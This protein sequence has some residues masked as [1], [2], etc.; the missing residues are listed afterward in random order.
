LEFVSGFLAILVILAF[1]ILIVY[2]LFRVLGDFA[3]TVIVNLTGRN[4]FYHTAFKIRKIQLQHEMILMQHFR[5]YRNLNP[6]KQRIFGSRLEKFMAGKNFINKGDELLTEKKKVLISATAIKLTFGIRKYMLPA[7]PTI[8]V[9]PQQYYSR[10]TGTYNKGE[11]NALGAVVFSWEDYI[12][13]YKIEDD[14][15]NVGLHEFAHA[16]ALQCYLD[17]GNCDKAFS[18]H[19]SRWDEA[20]NHP[21]NSRIIENSG[22]FREY[23]NQNNMELFA[24]AV[25][26]YFENPREFKEK[27]PPLYVIMMRMLNLE[28]V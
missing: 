9:Y 16:L 26:H 6:H 15:L 8:I 11:T 18:Y 4:P 23:A 24:V 5:F 13:G 28:L 10:F 21:S 1:L 14:N 22:L 2:F 19:L 17:S 20:V 3:E 25:E 12:E 7:F 27:L